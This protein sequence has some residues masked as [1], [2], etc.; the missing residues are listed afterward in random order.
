[1]SFFEG[2]EKKIEI[3]VGRECGRLLDRPDSYWEK[4]A[5]TCGAGILSQMGNV[6]LRAF[7]LSESGMFVWSDRL[8]ILTCGQTSLVESALFLLKEFGV[9]SIK[10]MIYQRKNEYRSH[11]QSSDFNSDVERMRTLV[12]G[13]AWRFGKVHGHYNLLFHL[14]RPF[15]PHESDRTTE[16]LMYDL[17]APLKDFLTRPGLTAGDIRSRFLEGG[18]FED[19]SIDD[20]CFN[21]C[22]YSFNAIKGKHYCTIHVTPQGPSSY[23]S[24][25]TNIEMDAE[26]G[27]ILHHLLD[28]FYPRS[29][30]LMAFNNRHGLN[31]KRDYFQVGHSREELSNGYQ[32]D[33]RCF[34]REFTDVEKAENCG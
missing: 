19:F 26:T 34:Y 9:E 3:V 11:L 4:V 29:F 18:F 31:F 33:F 8:L 20:F 22:G 25:E 2:A 21:P 14:N 15:V 32:V 30:D 7:L 6:H 23:A 12:E 27:A 28:I 24:F 13:Q 16:L 5:E 10:S 1:M 17:A